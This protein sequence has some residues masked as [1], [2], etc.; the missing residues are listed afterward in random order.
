MNR[1]SVGFLAML[2]T[3]K[4]PYS[5]I[6][7]HHLTRA[8]GAVAPRPPAHQKRVCIFGICMI[9]SIIKSD[10]MRIKQYPERASNSAA[11]PLPLPFRRTKFRCRAGLLNLAKVLIL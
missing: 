2:T 3:I 10:N 4:L 1:E 6:R 5:H 8:G 9:M 7:V 11:V